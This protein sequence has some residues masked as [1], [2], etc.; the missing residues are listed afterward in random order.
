MNTYIGQLNKWITEQRPNFGDN[1]LQTLLDFLWYNYTELNPIRS[2][3]IKKNDETLGE[4]LEALPVEQSDKLFSALC[5][6][7]TL[8]EHQAFLDGICVGARLVDELSKHGD[9]EA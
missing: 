1:S 2:D 4:I 3:E 9:C 7:C 6:L 5:A 8:H